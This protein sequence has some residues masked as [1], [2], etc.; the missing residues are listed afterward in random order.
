M[1]VLTQLFLTREVFTY[2]CP[3]KG[4]LPV[5]LPRGGNLGQPDRPFK[6]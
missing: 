2:Y 4:G 3:V 5:V 1:I 6:L